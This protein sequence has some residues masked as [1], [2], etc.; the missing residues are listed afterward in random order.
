MVPLIAVNGLVIVLPT[1]Q[2]IYYAFTNW[3]GYG[4]ARFI[5]LSNFEQ[6]FTSS[7]FWQAC[8]HN[9]EWTVFFLIVP[10]A[11]GLAGAFMLSRITR[12]RNL[13][14]TLFF[15]P[16]VLSTV[17]S[18]VIWE[19]LLN[20][21]GGAV[22]GLGIGFLSNIS[23]FGN[24]HLALGSVAF[25]NNWQ[26]WG[27]LVVMFL[28]AMQGIDPTL[29]EAARLD[30]ANT[31]KEFRHITVPTIRPV[32][33]FLMLMTVIWSF[34]VF[35]YIYIITQ[36]GPDNAD[37]GS[38]HSHVS[39][40]VQRPGRRLRLRHGLILRS[41]ERDHRDP[42]HQAA[43]A[44]VERMSAVLGSAPGTRSYQ[45]GVPSF[46]RGRRLTRP[47][48]YLALTALAV[49]S[50]APLVIVVFTAL[51]SEIGLAQNPIGPPVHPQWGNFV[52]A[53]NQ[54]SIGVGMENSAILTLGTIA[55]VCVIAGCA[56]Y[57]MAR[58]D[59]PGL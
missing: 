46:L 13:F 42:L 27:F 2:A 35:D 10:M 44:R 49:Y 15:I 45:A 41:A 6:M 36:G 17:V 14:R 53:W 56:A 8:Y 26:W 29:Y 23:F 48:F 43:T 38:R 55:G 40:G 39:G 4:R 18:A 24:T 33:M 54:G 12:F 34:L 31:W 59:L 22:S 51:K 9:L 37:A 47:F 30:G 25:V 19:N 57:A 58:L 52:Q 5:G 1:L 32:L 7:Q 50:L 11:M 16:Y 21:D 3:N 20:P 28:A